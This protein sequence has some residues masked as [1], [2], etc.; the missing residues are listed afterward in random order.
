MQNHTVEAY[1]NRRT[2]E[3]L[4]AF[5]Q[6]CMR[7]SL[8]EQYMDSV[9]SILDILQKRDLEIQENVITSWEAFLAIPKESNPVE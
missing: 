1:L 9:P 4:Q 2:T 8:W 7:K 6:Y 5:L 3:E